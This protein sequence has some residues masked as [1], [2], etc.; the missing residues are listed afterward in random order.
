L[1]QQTNMACRKERGLHYNVF[2]SDGEIVGYLINQKF[3]HWL[4][5]VNSGYF[6]QQSQFYLDGERVGVLERMQIRFQDGL[7]WSLVRVPF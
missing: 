1:W 2:S 5:G 6:D 3:Y 4:T 7:T